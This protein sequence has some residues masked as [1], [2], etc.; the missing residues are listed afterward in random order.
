MQVQDGPGQPGRLDRRPPQVHHHAAGP[1]GHRHPGEPVPEHVHAVVVE[2]PAHAGQGGAAGTA[3]SHPDPGAAGVG[4]LL[5]GHLP[6]E[7][8]DRPAQ[9]AGH[10]HLGDAEQI[11]DLLLGLVAV[12]VADH[13]AALPLRQ[14]AQRRQQVQ[15]VA[16]PVHPEV[17]L[18]Q[19]VL[20]LRRLVVPA[21]RPVQGNVP[22]RP[23]G[24]QRLHHHVDRHAQVPGHLVGPGRTLRAAGQFGLG[25]VHQQ[26]ALLQAPGHPDVPT[27]VPEVA[28][29]LAEDGRG[30]VADERHPAP[31]VVPVDRLD[32]A[33]AGHLH[34]VVEWFAAVGE[35]AGQAHSQRSMDLD[36]TVPGAPGGRAVGIAQGGEHLVDVCVGPRDGHGHGRPPRRQRVGRRGG[37]RRVAWLA[38]ERAGSAPDRRAEP[39]G[40]RGGPGAVGRHRGCQARATVIAFR[41][42]RR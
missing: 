18:G 29:Q 23:S 31:R 22:V 37:D 2:D 13:H 4:R 3:E 38:R 10:V 7:Q 42:R 1:F 32:Q 16:E 15:P 36:Q 12:E 8:P 27:V 25:G 17:P 9:Q 33:V 5:G 30:G 41:A 24:G 40:G 34:E 21:G 39:S 14:P 19:Q 6:P 35:A 11:A 20:P 26:V 28:L